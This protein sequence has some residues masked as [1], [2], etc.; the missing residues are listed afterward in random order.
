MLLPEYIILGWKNEQY[1]VNLC[2][3]DRTALPPNP[4]GSV[5]PSAIDDLFSPDG[6]G[7][8]TVSRT[9]ST[10]SPCVCKCPPVLLAAPMARGED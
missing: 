5:D 4:A 8:S 9:L 7:A 3:T 1:R 6:A 10:P 2:E